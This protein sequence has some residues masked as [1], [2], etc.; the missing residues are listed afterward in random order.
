MYTDVTGRIIIRKEKHLLNS[1][2]L[3]ERKAL[4][5]P[6]PVNTTSRESLEEKAC[7]HIHNEETS[8]R[9]KIEIWYE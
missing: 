5:K 4:R 1:L 6:T 7:G 9:N 3:L 8:Y 2:I